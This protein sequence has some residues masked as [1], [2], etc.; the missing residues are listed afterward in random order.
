MNYS[1]EP[2]LELK[3]Q[4]IRTLSTLQEVQTAQLDKYTSWV[5]LLESNSLYMPIKD[6]FNN[7]ILRLRSL[8]NTREADIERIQ[9]ES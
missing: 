7:E 1:E 4:R 8:I 5:E 9:H 6:H 3:L 2:K